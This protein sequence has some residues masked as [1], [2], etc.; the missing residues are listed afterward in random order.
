MK[1]TPPTIIETL[2]EFNAGI[3][4]AQAE[5][6]LKQ[7]ALGVIYHG[8]KNKKAKVTLTINLSRFDDPDKP[9]MVNVEHSWAFDHPTKR[10]KRTETNSTETPMHVSREGH[11][12]II[13]Y[14]QDDA[15]GKPAIVKSINNQPG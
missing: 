1:K 14:D 5:E 7:A 8:V 3:F 10:G 6:V 4:L 11:L 13:S 2:Q 9:D 12:S 15:F